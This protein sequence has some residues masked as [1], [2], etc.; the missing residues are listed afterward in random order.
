MGTAIIGKFAAEEIDQEQV[1]KAEINEK[2]IMQN[3]EKVE[4][5]LRLRLLSDEATS[6][7]VV[8]VRQSRKMRRLISPLSCRASCRRHKG[9]VGDVEN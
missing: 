9:T 7:A 5:D 6:A 1:Q 3:I 4:S 2:E 8:E